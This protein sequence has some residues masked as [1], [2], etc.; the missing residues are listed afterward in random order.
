MIPFTRLGAS[1]A[2]E[3]E[4]VE[5]GSLVYGKW[6]A[7]APWLEKPVIGDNCAE[8]YWLAMKAWTEAAK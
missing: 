7:S 3:L 1:L 8:A 6:S 5:P 4:P 2:V